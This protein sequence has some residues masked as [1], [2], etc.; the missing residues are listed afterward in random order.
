MI[1]EC[2]LIWKGNFTVSPADFAQVVDIYYNN[3]IQ[4]ASMARHTTFV[5]RELAVDN[6]G[7]WL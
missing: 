4:A 6:L 7:A 1:V 3:E 5:N 2:K